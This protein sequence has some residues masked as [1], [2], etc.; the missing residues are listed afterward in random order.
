MLKS[1]GIFS[2]NKN[3]FNNLL[4]GCYFHFQV[5]KKSIELFHHLPVRYFVEDASMGRSVDDLQLM[6]GCS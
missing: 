6:P 2:R 5:N 1:L 3:N 4:I